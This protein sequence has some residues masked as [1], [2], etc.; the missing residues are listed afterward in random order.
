M[1]TKQILNSFINYEVCAYISYNET[2]RITTKDT[3]HVKAMIM[4]TLRY[5]PV[6]PQHSFFGFW[7]ASL[8]PSSRASETLFFQQSIT[9]IAKTFPEPSEFDLYRL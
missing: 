8:L 6:F 7:N 5:L 1:A 3:L 9:T 4:F 2:F